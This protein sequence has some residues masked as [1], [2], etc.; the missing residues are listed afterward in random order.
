LEKY[1][2]ATLPQFAISD[3][4]SVDQNIQRFGELLKHL[5]PELGEVMAPK[6][7]DLADSDPTD[8]PS[9]WQALFNSLVPPAAEVGA[10]GK[11]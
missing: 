10:E 6:L 8:L 9:L 5:D 1:M 2:P 4:E 11:A 7:R 3:T